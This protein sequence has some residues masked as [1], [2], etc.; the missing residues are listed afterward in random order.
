MSEPDSTTQETKA[1]API[2]VY[3]IKA[4]RSNNLNDVEAAN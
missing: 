1:M 2:A 3:G 4:L